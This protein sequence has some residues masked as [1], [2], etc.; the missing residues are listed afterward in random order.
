VPNPGG[1][2]HDVA[3]ISKSD[4]WAVGDF[5]VIQH[6]NGRRWARVSAAGVE[7]LAGV[8]AFSANDVWAVGGERT[9]VTLHWNGTQ[10]RSVQNSG[11]SPLSDVAIISPLDVWAVGG[12]ENLFTMHWNGRRWTVF[13]GQNVGDQFS[14]LSSVTAGST[15]NVWAVG[16]AQNGNTLHEPVV[17]RWNGKSWRTDAVPPA[18]GGLRGVAVRSAHDVWTVGWDDPVLGGQGGT[19]S[20]WNGTTWRAGYGMKRT[21]LNAIS[22]DRGTH[23]WAVGSTGNP[24]D[25]SELGALGPTQRPIIFRYGC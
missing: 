18:D 17:Y 13:N 3:A 15:S 10:W 7:P 22:T 23:L 16:E 12:D 1:Q 6:W 5:G 14:W 11:G 2:L 20:H 25:E 9:A 19:I 4:A 21:M 8:A 24:I